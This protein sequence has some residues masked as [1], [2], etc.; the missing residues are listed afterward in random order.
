MSR[1]VILA[2]RARFIAADL[3]TITAGACSDSSAQA[4]LAPVGGAG[5]VSPD[6]SVDSGG[7]ADSAA[8]TGGSGGSAA[9]DSGSAGAAGQ[10]GAGGAP[11][12]AGND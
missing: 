1:D 11:D 6:G 12:D 5:G 2:R 8:A 9:S 10:A 3:A 4:C 7:D